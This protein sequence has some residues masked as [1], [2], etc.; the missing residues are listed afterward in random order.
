MER[1]R[2]ARRGNKK[3]PLSIRHIQQGLQ[4]T[5]AEKNTS[6]GLEN[7]FDY[8]ESTQITLYRHFRRDLLKRCS[9]KSFI[10][11]LSGKMSVI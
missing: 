6:L 3:I 1:R 2:T 4:K 5:K 9:E 10:M 8:D 11:T 7:A